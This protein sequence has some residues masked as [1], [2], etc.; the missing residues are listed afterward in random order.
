M[1]LRSRKNILIVDDHPIVRQGI[2]SL[3]QQE[4][5]LHIAGEAESAG[6]ALTLLRAESVDAAIIDISLKGT[7]GLELTK[8]VRAEFPH[9]PV[10][11]LSMLDETMYAERALRSGANGYLMKQEVADHIVTALRSVL[12]GRIFVSD[13][14]RE[15]LLGRLAGQ[16]IDPNRSPI[17]KLSD[18]ELEVFR[19]IGQG[20]GTREIAVRL[21][22]SIKTI[23]TYRSHI[24]EKLNIPNAIELVRQAV[25]LVEQDNAG[26]IPPP[27]E[28]P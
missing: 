4:P 18:R 5:D 10:L 17:E 9:L 12:Q 25:Q 6:R 24:K 8:A 27:P 28:S 26:P 19:M 13:R 14:V 16:P 22:L 3:L 2:R 7:D 11:I 21:H 20:V 15:T 1:I 23:E